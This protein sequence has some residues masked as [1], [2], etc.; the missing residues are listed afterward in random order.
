MLK[1]FWK[2][3]EVLNTSRNM[4]IWL[5]LETATLCFTSCYSLV[6]IHLAVDFT[7]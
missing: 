5:F 2:V 7:G 1:E 6:L 3:S 4:R